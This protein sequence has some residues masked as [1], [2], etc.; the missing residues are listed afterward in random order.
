MSDSIN[1]DMKGLEQTIKA[2]Q[3]I[4]DGAFKKR[5][6]KAAE[7][8]AGKLYL[9][10]VKR[11]ALNIIDDSGE[12][13][14]SFGIIRDKGSKE[15]ITTKYGARTTGKY[16]AKRKRNGSYE[17]GG[18][19][20]HFYEQGTKDRKTKSGHK[21]GRIEKTNFQSKAFKAR[22]NVAQMKLKMELQK[23]LVKAINKAKQKGMKF[24]NFS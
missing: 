24:N 5:A 9:D 23:G 12:L 16:R 20:A 10:K 13:S 2:F 11:N 19:L 4:E 15:W 1:F 18:W 6:V 8:K 7:R 22:K 3:E 21:T 17:S 14:E